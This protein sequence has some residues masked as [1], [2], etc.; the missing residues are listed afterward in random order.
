MC[1]HAGTIR[2][3]CGKIKDIRKHHYLSL[4]PLS[5]S[6]FLSF[7]LSLSFSFSPSL[8]PSLPHSL[9]PSFPAF[10][11]LPPSLSPPSLSLR[12]GL[13]LILPIKTDSKL[14]LLQDSV[15]KG[16]HSTPYNARLLFPY[17]EVNA[18]PTSQTEAVC[19]TGQCP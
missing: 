11:S 17:K 8:P 7:S 19:S 12:G 10:P 5:L 3:L 18:P 9:S 14:A 2:S 16:T 4:S 6:P 15:L 13:V 1:I